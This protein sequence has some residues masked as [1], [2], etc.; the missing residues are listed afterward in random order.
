MSFAIELAALFRR[1]IARLVQEVQ[2]FPDEAS[3]WETRPG[4]SNSAGNL[5]LHLEGNLRDF[6]GR[7]LGGVEYTR[8]RELEFSSKGVQRE[9]LARRLE[10]VQELVFGTVAGLEPGQMEEVVA[11][12]KDVAECAVVGIGDDMKGQIP[13]GFIVLNAGVNRPAKEIESEVVKL[14]REEIGPV[15]AF[16]SVMV[17]KRL[18]KTR[19]GKILRGTMRQIADG[20]SWKMP[21]TID[22][23][24]ILDEIGETMK[25][26]GVA[27]S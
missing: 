11:K 6:I 21:A 19:S 8:Q 5:A 12:H 16:K 24:A 1:D 15:A 7:Q 4:V 2:A 3:L 20:E 25:A 9:E 17:V 13:A 23:P 22:D 26:Y 27:K 18:P 14:V 10:A